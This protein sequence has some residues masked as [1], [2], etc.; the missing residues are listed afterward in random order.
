VRADRVDYG[1][2]KSGAT[3]EHLE[4]RPVQSR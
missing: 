1:E 2:A 4:A 3:T